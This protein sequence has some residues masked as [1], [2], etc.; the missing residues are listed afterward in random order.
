[1]ELHWEGS[2]INGATPSSLLGE[3][4]KCGPEEGL[5]KTAGYSYGLDGHYGFSEK[6]CCKLHTPG[7]EGSKSKE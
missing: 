3:R 4:C 1:M 5:E 7:K 6:V 2:A